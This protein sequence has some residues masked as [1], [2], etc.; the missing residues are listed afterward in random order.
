MGVF[1]KMKAKAAARRAADEVAARQ[2][3][4][5]AQAVARELAE[6]EAAKKAERELDPAARIQQPS[7]IAALSASGVDLSSVQ[8]VLDGSGGTIFTPGGS[9]IGMPK[10][11]NVGIGCVVL[12]TD[13]KLAYVLRSDAGVD[14]VVRKKSEV[15]Q[16]RKANSD[17][18]VWIVFEGDRSFPDRGDQV[19][20]ADNWDLPVRDGNPNA[21]RAVFLKAGYS[22]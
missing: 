2:R 7:W 9:A 5:D 11:R 3:A 4:A 15:A 1:D 16:M 22:V 14:V 10:M 18:S 17:R 8:A 19:G 6:D 13:D 21:I 12:T 20:R